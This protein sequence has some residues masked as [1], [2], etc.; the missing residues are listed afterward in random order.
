MS[1]SPFPHDPSPPLLETIRRHEAEI[2]RR[3]AAERQAVDSYLAG[4]EQSSRQLV[5]AA[6]AEGAREG[7]AQRQA[8]GAQAEREAEAIVAQAYAEAERLKRVGAER[9]A[10]AAARAVAIVIGGAHET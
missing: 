10:P 4:V 6:E 9:M 1:R 3:L 8:L 5:A 2:K 7:E